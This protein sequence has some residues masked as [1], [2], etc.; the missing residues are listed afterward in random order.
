MEK[1]REI[2]PYWIE[3]KYIAAA[4]M[5][6]VSFLLAFVVSSVVARLCMR[7]A[8]RTSTT[9][10]NR[11]IEILHQPVRVTVVL[12]GLTAA[13]ARLTPP[14]EAERIV[15]SVLKTIAILV[16]TGFTFRFTNLILTH[17]RD[18]RGQRIVDPQTKPLFENL[19]KIIAI[20]LATYFV[21]VSWNINVSA[22]LASAGIIGIAVGF[23]AKDTL[24]NLF[25][26]IFIVA[27][28]PYKVGDYINLDTGERGKV[29][30]IGLRST[31]MLTRDDIEVTLPNA[32]I[33]NAKIVNESS[34]PSLRQR[35]RIKVGVAYGSDVDRLREVLLEIALAHPDVCKDPEP[36]V[37][38]RQFGES[39]LDHELLCWVDDPVLR[40]PV[41]DALLTSVY[42]RLGEERIEI[43]YPKR[44][45]YIKQMPDIR[46][47]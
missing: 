37:R 31:R 29:T 4:V 17:V 32:V 26:G 46:K 20:A 36:R 2:I 28:A 16:W 30:H 13:T 47:E 33:A 19:A 38:F 5:I 43:P 7:L 44:D 42:K 8:R 40:G 34:G 10:D 27:D 6:V 14:A 18:L 11:L 1:F 35:L 12:L 45:V 22:W 24:A 39:S 23:A 25:S 21:F 15:A 9:F 41:L 3:N